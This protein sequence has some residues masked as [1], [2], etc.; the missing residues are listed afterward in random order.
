M[1]R[2]VLVSILV[3]AASMANADTPSR[4]RAPAQPRAS[5]VVDDDALGTVT[6]TRG[7][8]R[9]KTPAAHDEARR[10][11]QRDRCDRVG[12]S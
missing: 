8:T 5:A 2:A 11:A 10:I 4:S 3:T 1:H 7:S 6:F 12:R 9:L